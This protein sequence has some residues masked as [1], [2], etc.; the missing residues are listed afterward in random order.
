MGKSHWVG[1]EA[2]LGFNRGLLQRFAHAQGLLSPPAVHGT[3]VT[4]RWRVEP[5]TK[6]YKKTCF[7]MTFPSS[8]DISKV[9]DRLWWDIFFM[10]LHSQWLLLRPCEVHLPLRLSAG[11]RQFWLELLRNGAETLEAYGSEQYADDLGIDILDGDVEVQRTTIAGSGYG[12]AFSGGKDSLLQA[13]MLFEFTERPLLVTTTSPLPPLSD[14]ETRRRRYV[15]NEIQVRRDPVFVEVHSDFRST[16]DDGFAWLS[17]RISVNELT[18][19]FL[20]MSSLFAVG[21]A[22]GRTR[23]S[24]RLKLKFKKMLLSVEE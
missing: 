1:T 5:T 19:T 11:E 2:C 9:P 16:W 21:A 12:T 23:C 10:C 8:V 3:T 22:L 13:A 18:D 20:Y 6:L 14:H 4:F 24:S 17:Y 7:T 15:L